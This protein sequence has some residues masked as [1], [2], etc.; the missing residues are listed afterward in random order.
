MKEAELKKLTK[1][2]LEKKVKGHKT[3]IGIFIVVI[4][5]FIYFMVS[6]YLKGREIDSSISLITICSLGGMFALFPE[7]KAIQT[8][9]KSRN[10]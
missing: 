6:D 2:A 7:L 8:E 1:E 9:L 4:A 10:N 5:A 3:L